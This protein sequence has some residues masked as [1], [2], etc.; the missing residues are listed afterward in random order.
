MFLYRDV[1]NISYIT[2]D[3]MFILYRTSEVDIIVMSNETVF[4]LST[5]DFLIA[6]KNFFC[7]V[8]DHMVDFFSVNKKGTSVT[9]DLVPF[10]TYI[11][12]SRPLGEISNFR[13]LVDRDLICSI[14]SSNIVT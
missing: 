3:T 7:D 4:I 1:P 12:R 5:D 14:I 13:S 11:G 10:K 6:V 8:H 2:T 9:S